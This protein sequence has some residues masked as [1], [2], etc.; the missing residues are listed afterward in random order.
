MV[1]R[2]LPN[3]AVQAVFSEC[4]RYRY[5]LNLTDTTRSPAKTV[6]VVMQNPSIANEEVADKSVQFLEKLIFEKGLPQFEEVHR[7][8]IVNQFGKVQTKNFLGD[9]EDIGQENDRHLREAIEEADTVLIA[10][11]KNNPYVARQEFI[12]ELVRR[13]GKKKVWK[14][15]KHPS[16]GYYRDFIAPLVF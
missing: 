13:S 10:W 8:R 2:H 9:P 12:L 3:I 14:T 16:R 7:C 1:Y 15:R 5:L 4:M 11:G 6:C